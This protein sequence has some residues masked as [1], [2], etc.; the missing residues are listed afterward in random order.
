MSDQGY[1]VYVSIR[2]PSGELFSVSRETVADLKQDLDVFLGDGSSNRI[3][4]K[5]AKAVMAEGAVV[6]TSAG[7]AGR[8]PVAGTPSLNDD[9]PQSDAEALENVVKAFPTA[10]APTENFKACERCGTLKDKWVPPGTSKAGKPYAGFYSC[11][12]YRN[13]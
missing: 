4:A 5:L 2:L 11:P 3:Q 10:T 8:G 12:N 6:A 1:G 9:A 13:H 7:S